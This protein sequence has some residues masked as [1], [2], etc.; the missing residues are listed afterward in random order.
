MRFPN[1]YKGIKKMFLGGI[2][3]AAAVGLTVVLA[4]MMMAVGA[5]TDAD[6]AALTR[7][8]AL[9]AGMLSLGLVLAVVLGL[10]GL[11][12]DFVGVIHAKKDDSH[13]SAALYTALLGIVISFIVSFLAKNDPEIRRWLSLGGTVCGILTRVFVLSGIASLA[14]KMADGKIKAMAEKARA[15]IC[16]VSIGSAAAMLIAA[17][18]PD[19]GPLQ[20]VG[21]GLSIGSVVYYLTVLLKARKMLA[22]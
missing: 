9:T 1:A 11:I 6:M 17:Y 21:Y 5:G 19:A 10:V 18:L 3:M 22:G 15:I 8:K 20:F 12:L 4:V 14:A 2:M 7:D 13:F 16:A